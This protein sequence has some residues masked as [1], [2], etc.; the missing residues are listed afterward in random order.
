MIALREQPLM[1]MRDDLI[2][3]FDRTEL[4][5]YLTDEEMAALPQD[6]P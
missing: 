6:V 4:G 1:T 3:L 5:K 2:A